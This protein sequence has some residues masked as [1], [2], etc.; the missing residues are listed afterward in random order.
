LA[1]DRPQSGDFI[2]ALPGAHHDADEWKEAPRR[3]G[4]GDSLRIRQLGLLIRDP[5]GIVGMRRLKL[6][7]IRLTQPAALPEIT[8]PRC[9]GVP[10]R[11][12]A[13]PFDAEKPFIEQ[14]LLRR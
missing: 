11:K 4:Q 1:G 9:G 8:N 2:L 3:I 10:S 5:G 6:P 13:V 12:N 7:P 14:S